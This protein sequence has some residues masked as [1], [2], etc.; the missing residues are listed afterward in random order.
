[1]REERWV[2]WAGVGISNGR[3]SGAEIHRG[4]THHELEVLRQ[5]IQKL[6][7]LPSGD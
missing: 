5:Q 2:A 4:Y 7:T 1:M 3:L 6:S